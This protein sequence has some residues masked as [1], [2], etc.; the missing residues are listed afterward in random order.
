MQ[1][2]YKLIG[3]ISLMPKCKLCPDSVPNNFSKKDGITFKNHYSNS[4]ENGTNINLQRL[5][6]GKFQAHCRSQILVEKV[7]ENFKPH[8][9]I[10]KLRV[11]VYM[12]AR[13]SICALL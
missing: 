9:N 6:L 7:L 8:N 4:F 5:D 1:G 13:S 3:F 10:K 2:V 11:N 12:G